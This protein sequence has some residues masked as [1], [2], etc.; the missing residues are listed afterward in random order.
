MGRDGQ[1]QQRQPAIFFIWKRDDRLLPYL[2]RPKMAT[3]LRN[4]IQ[5]IICLMIYTKEN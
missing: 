3:F 4:R 1:Q 2:T 5:F